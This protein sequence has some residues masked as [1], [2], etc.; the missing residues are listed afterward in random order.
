MKSL[1]DRL[2]PSNRHEILSMMLQLVSLFRQISEYD[3]FL[4]PS[5]YL[6]HRIDTTDI[7]KSIWRKWDIASDSA[8]P[9]GV[10]RR[11]GEWRGSSNLVWVKTGNIYIS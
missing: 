10:E 7:I 8:L 9:D 1:L 4:G 11:W 3:A 2:I 5:R 6:T